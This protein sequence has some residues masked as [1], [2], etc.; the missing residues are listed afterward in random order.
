MKFPRHIALVLPLAAVAFASVPRAADAQSLRGS[1]AS[2]ERMY[3]SAH[4]KA[5]HFYETRAGV[6]QAA[7]AGRFVAIRSSGQLALHSVSHPVVLPRTR[8]V[9]L[10]L[11]SRYKSACGQRLVVT[12]AVR[13]QSA[14][15]RNASDKSVHPTGM[16]V[17]IRKPSGR[18]LTWLRREL[19]TME[20]QG[21]VE[22]TEE[23]RPPHFHVAVLKAPPTLGTSSVVQAGA[24][25][26][27]ST[28]GAAA[29][30]TGAAAASRTGAAVSR[31][32]VRPGDT[33][34][35]IADRHDTTVRTLMELN[36][37][38]SSR[39]QPGERLAVR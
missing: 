38:T 6:R 21:I 1:R 28:R 29:S 32:T 27:P 37:K 35:A 11:A 3:R 5:L 13:P 15:P 17:D 25:A 4:A 30:R 39:I 36:G 2:V 22:A 26:A 33:L 19:I 12:S 16:A 14:Q 31:Y 24:A 9:L 7:A 18:C 23:R 20:R 10:D 8:S 34:G